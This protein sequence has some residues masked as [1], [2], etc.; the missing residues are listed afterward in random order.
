MGYGFEP[1]TEKRLAFIC[2]W[3]ARNDF[4]C[5]C[6]HNRHCP[7]ETTTMLKAFNWIS[8][9]GFG[10]LFLKAKMNAVGFLLKY[11][12]KMAYSR[13]NTR[14]SMWFQLGF[15]DHCSS[16]GLEEPP[17]GKD[18][19]LTASNHHGSDSL[20]YRDSRPMPDGEWRFFGNGGTLVDFK[21]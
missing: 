1:Y 7:W 9:A 6:R 18:A 2:I 14:S 4:H 20:D 15:P 16:D 21:E 19:G 5:A 8:Q 3:T 13:K 12:V 17:W 10:E 11:M